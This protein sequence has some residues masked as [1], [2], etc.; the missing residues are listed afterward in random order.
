MADAVK[1]T[2]VPAQTGFAEAVM[3]TLT[4]RP[5]VTVMQIMFEVAGFPVIQGR[6]EVSS[7]VMQSPLTGINVKVGLFDP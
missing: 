6:Y 7:H 5:V 3:V 2:K 1:I 4:G